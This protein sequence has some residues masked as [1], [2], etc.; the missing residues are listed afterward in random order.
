MRFSSHHSISV[1]LAASLLANGSGGHGFGHSHVGGDDSH[2][3]A[4][5]PTVAHDCGTHKCSHRHSNAD[6]HPHEVEIQ[7]T[8]ASIFHTHLNLFGFDFSVPASDNPHDDDESRSSMWICLVDDSA[9]VLTART[10]DIDLLRT[11]SLKPSADDV[12]GSA[13]ATFTTP[14]VPT[15]PLCDSARFER[16]GVLLI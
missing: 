11:L 9:V 16:S 10:I 3:H 13:A 15:A 6:E 12:T 5:E 1:L 8:L 7:W 4:D 2:S 14:Q